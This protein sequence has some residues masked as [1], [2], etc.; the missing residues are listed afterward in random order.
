[1][2]KQYFKEILIVILG[3]I[4]ILLATCNK[5]PEIVYKEVTVIDTV[6]FDQKERIVEVP[7]TKYIRV[8]KTDTITVVSESQPHFNQYEQPY[9]DSL[10][11]GTITNTVDGELIGTRLTYT[12]KF[13][14]YI[15]TTT[16]ITKTD[17]VFKKVDKT[18]LC[19]GVSAIA[20]VEFNPEISLSLSHKRFIYQIGYNPLVKSPR[21]GINYK[22]W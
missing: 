22:L 16:T 8:S 18:V 11:A 21:I 9:E 2:L 15:N 1:M 4:I 3:L 7:V 14:K 13:P 20:N 5:K 17:T 19:V 10:I 12:P 6:F